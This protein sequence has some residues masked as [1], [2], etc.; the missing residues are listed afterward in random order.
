[1]RVAPRLCTLGGMKREASRVSGKEDKEPGETGLRRRLEQ[2]RLELRA[3][4]RALDG[5][6]VAQ[7]VP[8]A[9]RRLGEW[10]ADFAEALW[11]LKQPK[12]R[13]NMAAMRR[14]T[15]K[16]LEALGG[17]RQALLELLP[18]AP[19]QR[20]EAVAVEIRAKL[21]AEEA[22]LDIPE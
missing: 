13:F 1:L 11:V 10:D 2:A 19:R 16:S 12:G 6:R 17:A 22:Y 21:R 18:E 3:L 4:Y 20:V 5:L 9:L 15:Q 14:D 7:E 8:P